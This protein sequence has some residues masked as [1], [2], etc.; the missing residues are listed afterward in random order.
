MPRSTISLKIPYY[1]KRS[2]RRTVSIACAVGIFLCVIFCGVSALRADTV[3]MVDGRRTKGIV[4]ERYA[5]RILFSTIEGEKEI[6][7]SD[8]AKIEYDE[9]ED[10]LINM[11]DTAFEKGYYR[12]A[13]KYYNMAYDINP[14]INV[15]KK[16]T[17]RT[18]AIIYRMPEQRKMTHM[19]I[20]NE[21]VAGRETAPS[22]DDKSPDERLREELGIGI[23]KRG[24]SFYI[25]A[26]DAGSPFK[27]AGAAK[28]DAIAAV[29]GKLCDYLTFDD[30]QDFMLDP[31]SVMI[32]VTVERNLK[33]EEGEP[34]DGTLA[35]EWEGATVDRVSKEG[36]AHNAG[37]RKGD[38]LTAIDGSSLR[39]TPLDTVAKRLQRIR[40]DRIVRVKRDLDIIKTR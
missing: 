24:N 1:N 32:S 35:M 20:K 26:I 2:F 3:T 4:V 21:I 36:S 8:I 31:Q 25:T 6:L 5:D 33:L 16:K 22:G 39:Y 34:F 17:L 9:A 10:N 15:L 18:E 12:A 19:E 37:F 14:A 27:R 38:L 23:T 40:D 28:G 13:L 11:G 29:W 7:K 30:L